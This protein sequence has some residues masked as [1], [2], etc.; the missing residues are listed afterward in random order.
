MTDREFRYPRGVRVWVPYAF[1]EQLQTNRGMLAMTAVARLRAGL[2]ESQLTARLDAEAAWWNEEYFRGSEF[3]K[4]LHATDFV[5][6][7]AGQ[8]RLIV[9]V[10]MGAVVF[11]LM[12]AA[13]NVGRLQLVRA[14]A[15][16][17]R[18]P[19][20][21]SRR[22]LSAESCTVEYGHARSTIG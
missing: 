6:Y 4:V 22:R 18:G 17:H 11:V 9:L 5:G 8:L 3:G 10:L 16:R 19:R 12:I 20:H 1:T 14:A 21:G 2:G 7:H 15:R 13:A